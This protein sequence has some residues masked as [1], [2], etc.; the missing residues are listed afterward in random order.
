MKVVVI[1]NAEDLPFYHS[2]IEKI[3][4]HVNA[5]LMGVGEDECGLLTEEMRLTSR[6]SE[7]G[8]ILLDNETDDPELLDRL[9]TLLNIPE[10]VV[11]HLTD[12]PHM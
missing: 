3:E 5:G 12:I 7:E 11:K 1:H 2:H 8:P 9:E 6:S 10:D 4:R